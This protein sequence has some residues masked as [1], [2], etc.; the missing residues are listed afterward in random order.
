MATQAGREK[1][2]SR[3]AG[4][5]LKKVEN[6]YLFLTLIVFLF[7]L[8]KHAS[9]RLNTT[10]EAPA[11]WVWRRKAIC[12]RCFLVSY[13]GVTVTKAGGGSSVGSTAQC[14]GR[15]GCTRSIWLMDSAQSKDSRYNTPTITSIVMMGISLL[16]PRVDSFGCQLARKSR[17][18]LFQNSFSPCLFELF[19]VKCWHMQWSHGSNRF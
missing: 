12:C 6:V 5:M 15:S 17:L 8:G 9:L 13:P 3:E 16:F 2:D 7:F 19:V 1:A 4:K 18:F 10:L 14:G 11:V